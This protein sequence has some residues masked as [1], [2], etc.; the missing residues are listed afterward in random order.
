MATELASTPTETGSPCVACRLPLPIIPAPVNEAGEFWHCVKCNTRHHGI[1]LKKPPVA[2]AGN[3]RASKEVKQQVPTTTNKATTNKATTNKAGT[4]KA[5]TDK[6]G[7]KTGS[8]QPATPTKPLPARTVAKCPV[9]TETTKQLDQQ[10]VRPG[11]LS[12]TLSGP[13]FNS[14]VKQHGAQK[15]D[16]ATEGNFVKQYSQSSDQVESMIASLEKGHAFDL[17]QTQ[18]VNRES[19]SQ[20]AED[21]DLFVKLGINPPDRNYGGKH[22]YHVAMLAMSMGVTLGWDEKT[23][24]ELGIGCLLHDIGM[25][26]V[27]EHIRNS[28]KILGPAEFAQIARH[29]LHTFDIL[30]ASTHS[31]PSLSR[32]V[33]YQI[34]ERCNGK[35]YPRNRTADSIHEA[36]KVAAVADVF[37]ALTS[38]RPHRPAMLPHFAAVHM[39]L[40]VRDGEFDSKS[41]R[42]LL[43]T[44]SLYPIGSFLELEDGRVG[45]VMRAHGDLYARPVVELWRPRD[46]GAEAEVVD[47]AEQEEAE[48]LGPITALGR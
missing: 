4:N 2:I 6:D 41:V 21:M 8:K 12:I 44:T 22:N 48:I 29:P 16:K 34:H 5:T 47:L 39:L 19:L 14:K 38:A 23:L 17:G 20:I 10:V 13:A 37:I 7:A 18:A 36:A 24:I 11:G 32:I 3:V 46:L 27:P 15:Y 45:K 26:R 25:S 43:K 31:I 35:G 28:D 30:E 40:G 42:A 9:E 33:A 1:L